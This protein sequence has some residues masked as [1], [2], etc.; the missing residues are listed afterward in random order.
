V[1]DHWLYMSERL[2][3]MDRIVNPPRDVTA[4][5][6]AALEQALEEQAAASNN[7]MASNNIW[8]RR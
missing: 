2:A 4:G 1:D 5:R 6:I 3:A 8:W 7:I